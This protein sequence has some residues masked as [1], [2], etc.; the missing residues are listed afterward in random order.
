VTIVWLSQPVRLILPVFKWPRINGM[1]DFCGLSA[2]DVPPANGALTL[3]R[4]CFSG[5]FQPVIPNR[6]LMLLPWSL[7]KVG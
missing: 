1:A 7:Y 2:K 5:D 3:I 4:T 6:I